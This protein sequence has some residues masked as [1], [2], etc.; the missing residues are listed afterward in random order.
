MRQDVLSARW[1]AE[2]SD[3]ALNPP[4]A[5]IV[6][7]TRLRWHKRNLVGL[8]KNDLSHWGTGIQTGAS[9]G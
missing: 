4:L 9:S 2:N 8:D 6:P 1:N 5:R 3:K 7:G